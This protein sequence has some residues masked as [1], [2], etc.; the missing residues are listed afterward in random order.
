MHFLDRSTQTEH[1]KQVVENDT[2][3]KNA[4]DLNLNKTELE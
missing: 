1:Y 2:V 3:I 4:I